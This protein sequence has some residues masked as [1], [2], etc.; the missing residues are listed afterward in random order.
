MAA[1]APES[2]VEAPVREAAQSAMARFVQMPVTT[3][4]TIISITVRTRPMHPD[5]MATAGFSRRTIASTSVGTTGTSRISPA[6][7]HAR[8]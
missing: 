4:T 3:V 1:Q 8:L 7:P 5:A 2:E 6:T